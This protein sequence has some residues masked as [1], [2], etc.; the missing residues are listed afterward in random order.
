MVEDI[1]CN[2]G[3]KQ[4]FPLSPTLSGIYIDKL[5]GCLEEAGCAGM[6]LAV[7]VII[8]LLYGDDIVLLVRC[9]SDL[10][11]QL[12]LLK[13][14]CSTMGMTVNTNKTKVMI[15][16]SKKDSYANFVYDNSNL[17]EVSSYKYLGI[18]I[19]H[20][21][22]WNYRIEKG[23]M[24]GGKLILVLKIIVNQTIWS[25]RIKIS[26]SSKLLSSMLSCMFLKYG[27]VSFLENLGGILS[28]YKSGL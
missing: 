14:F 11:K 25:C 4:G 2:I 13:D 26:S 5:E 21:L 22:N 19:H 23:L 18:Y 15:I 8:L 27:G 20:K 3:V 9:S 10:D 24:E 7:I 6:I 16:K 28:K 12:I 1:K 17:E